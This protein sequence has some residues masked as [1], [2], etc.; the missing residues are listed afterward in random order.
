MRDGSVWVRVEDSGPG[1]PATIREVLFQPFTTSG[2][3]NGLGLGLA[4]SR[5]SVQAHGGEL[6]LDRDFVTGT[7]F[8][9]RLPMA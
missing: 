7:R 8:C 5:E 9:L 3:K 4:L 6:W 2:K 1:V